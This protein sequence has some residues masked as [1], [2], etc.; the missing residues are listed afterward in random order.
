MDILFR[1]LVGLIAMELLTGALLKLIHQA[2]QKMRGKTGTFGGGAPATLRWKANVS[3]CGQPTSKP[4]H[5]LHELKQGMNTAN[6]PNGHIATRRSLP[7]KRG[8][9]PPGWAR[10]IVRAAASI[11]ELRYPRSLHAPNRN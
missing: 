3:R 10:Q 2:L 6:I 1:R 8:A 5:N 11:R 9:C 7:T 4:I